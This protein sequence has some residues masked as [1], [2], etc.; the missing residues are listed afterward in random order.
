MSQ[1]QGPLE[2]HVAD[3]ALDCYFPVRGRVTPWSQTHGAAT[4][5][6]P[7]EQTSSY[8]PMQWKTSFP[9][10]YLISSPYRFSSAWG[11]H[12]HSQQ[13]PV[14]IGRRKQ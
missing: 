13:D 11:L 12:G 6:P 10:G 1:P 9:G 5:R 8:D 2:Q 3:W 4:C 7:G 14:P